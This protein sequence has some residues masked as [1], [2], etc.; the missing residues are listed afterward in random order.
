L[1]QR[2]T[3]AEALLEGAVRKSSGFT[4]GCHIRHLIT[5]DVDLP[6]SSAFASLTAY[7]EPSSTGSLMAR[8]NFT[9]RGRSATGVI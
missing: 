1:P 6:Q 9:A 2:T 5:P 8:R 7:K 4:A 3:V